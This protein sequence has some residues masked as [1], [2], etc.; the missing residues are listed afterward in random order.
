MSCYNEIR[1][2]A[3][4]RIVIP[5]V[6]FGLFIDAPKWALSPVIRCVARHA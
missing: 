4:V 6:V 5:A 1:N 2:W 3:G